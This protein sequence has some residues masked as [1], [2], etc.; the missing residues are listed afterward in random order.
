[1]RVTMAN[2]TLDQ[3]IQARIQSFLTELSTLVR[4]AALESVE[5]ALAGGGGAVRRGPG[6]PRASSVERGPA[7][8]PQ[9][10][11][12]KS[13]RR[14]RR[15]TE[16]IKSI[17]ARVFAY[18]QSNAGQRLEEI[19]RGL[20]TDTDIL[21]RPLVRLVAEGKLR[22]EG[23]KRGTKYFTTGGGNRATKGKSNRR[24]KRGRKS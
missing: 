3:D 9:V 8:P 12:T 19:G 6:R 18:V 16:D 21:K 11:V 13:G 24:A 2:N 23:A 22:S 14:P 20:K 1:M 5:E 10:G 7:R 15:S 4:R 17:A